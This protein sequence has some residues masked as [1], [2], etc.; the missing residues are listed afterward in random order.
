VAAT[1]DGNVY[2]FGGRWGGQPSAQIWRFEIGT[3]PKPGVTLAPV[4]TLPTP[5]ADAAVAVLGHRA[6][7]VGGE[8]PALLTSVSI[9]EAR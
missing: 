6:Y 5:V 8:S 9:L 2:V 3:S 1:L 7:L 4:A